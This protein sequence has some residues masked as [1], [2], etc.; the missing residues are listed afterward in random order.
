MYVVMVVMVVMLCCDDCDVMLY[1]NPL[2]MY[3]VA[4]FGRTNI[5]LISKLLL[6]D[7]FLLK[8]KK[9]KRERKACLKKHPEI[10]SKNP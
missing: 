5:E 2:G 6:S 4:V 7:S 9:K 10:D 8:K 3:C 1:C